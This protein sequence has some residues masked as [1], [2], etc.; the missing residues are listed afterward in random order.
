MATS[1][2]HSLITGDFK[3]SV[4]VCS[5]KAPYW[6]RTIQTVIIN[7]L[8]GYVMAK[9]TKAR[10]K[11]DQLKQVERLRAKQRK[12]SIKYLRTARTELNDLGVELDGNVSIYNPKTNKRTTMTIEQFKKIQKTI[13]M[14]DIQSAGLGYSQSKIVG[15]YRRQSDSIATK[16]LKPFQS[17]KQR[18]VVKSSEWVNKK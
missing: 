7:D 1:Q 16:K 3:H 11:R 4:I 12:L 18:H 2:R 13:N 8:G 5:I 14:S 15:Q 6:L 10:I 9:R 17:Y